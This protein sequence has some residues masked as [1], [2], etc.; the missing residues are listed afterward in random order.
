MLAFIMQVR[1]PTFLLNIGLVL[2]CT[3]VLCSQTIDLLLGHY[4]IHIDYRPVAGE[5]DAGWGFF[6]SFDTDND[7]N[8]A[9]GITRLDPARVRL[10]A[11]PGTRQTINAATARLGPVGEPF[12][13]WPQNNVP[14]TLFLGLRTVIAPGLFQSSVNGFYSPSPLGNIVLEMTA[15]QGTGPEAGGRLALWE[16]RSLGNL[17]FHFDS[18]KAAVDNRLEPVAVGS[19]THYNWGLSKPGTY[20]VTFRARGRLNPWQENGGQDTQGEA[21]FTFA[22]PF[23]G[24]LESGAEL[25]L[26]DSADSPCSLYHSLEQCEY[27]PARAVL[28]AKPVEYRG[29]TLPHGLVLTVTA[30]ADAAPNRVGING[31]RA[32]RMPPGYQLANPSLELLAA[33]GPGTVAQYWLA[34]G[35]PLFDFSAGGIYR[36]QLRA[37]YLKDDLTRSVGHPFVLTVLAGLPVDYPYASWADSYEITHHLPPGTLADFRQDYDG[38]GIANGLEYQLFWHGFDPGEKDAD[39]LPQP[40]HIEG[41]WGIDFIRDTYKDD[42]FR[43]PYR[44]VARYSEDLRDW[45]F[46]HTNNPSHPGA[47]VFEN[48][49]DSSSIGRIQLRRL[50]IPSGTAEGFFQWQTSVANNFQ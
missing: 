7:F 20:A 47:A 39:R 42:L 19:H 21:T 38:D 41:R 14:G 12:W 1:M 44:L 36:L 32:L 10:V 22:V 2:L 27:A 25:R 37:H 28:L 33:T 3:N 46:W 43:S 17:E 26:S 16:S 15:V 29:A 9:D 31:V 45:M 40:T 35:K 6:V 18:S 8:D 13:L 30:E 4:E 23:S 34:A 49:A 50:E 5:A 11:A 48:A 24:S